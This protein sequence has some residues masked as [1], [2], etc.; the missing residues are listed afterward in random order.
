MRPFF[1]WLLPAVLFSIGMNPVHAGVTYAAAADG[2]APQ[3]AVLFESELTLFPMTYSRPGEELFY[4]KTESERNK[5]IVEACGDGRLCFPSSDMAGEVFVAT[6]TAMLVWSSDDRLY[7]NRLRIEGQS[8]HSTPVAGAPI[9]YAGNLTTDARG[10]VQTIDYDSGHYSHGPFPMKRLIDRLGGPQKLARVL[11]K[12]PDVSGPS[13]D[14]MVRPVMGAIDFYRY[15]EVPQDTGDDVTL[16][17]IAG[18]KPSDDFDSV[19]RLQPLVWQIAKLVSQQEKIESFLKQRADVELSASA[20]Q[21]VEQMLIWIRAVYDD[22]SYR[23]RVV[24]A[25][26]VNDE[27]WLKGS[28]GYFQQ[29]FYHRLFE[30]LPDLKAKLPQRLTNAF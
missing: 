15:C 8:H 26:R 27:R 7:I 18:E 11:V 3:C 10:D 29:R 17:Y 25:F 5:Q 23:A 19:T 20:D 28:R 24:V 13:L 30:A 12:L 14:S 9:R 22:D 1:I 4:L 2:V 21:L 6:E 16:R